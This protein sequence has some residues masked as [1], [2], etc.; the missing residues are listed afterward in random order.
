MRSNMGT[1][2][3][4]LV[5]ALLSVLVVSCMPNRKYALPTLNIPES[6]P[7]AESPDELVLSDVAWYELYAGAEL[8]SLI[9]KALE[10]NKDMV[11]AAAKVREVAYLRRISGAAFLPEIGASL[12]A[13]RDWK[14]Y[15]GDNASVTDRFDAKLTFSWEIDLTGRL[16]WARKQAV[17]EYLQS[18][19]A[20]RALQ[21]S[22][23][24]QVAG[25]YFELTALCNELEIVRQTLTMREEAVRQARLR[26]EGGLTDE[27]PYR[28]AQVELAD[29]SA[30]IPGMERLMSGKRNEIMMLCGDF[31]GGGHIGENVAAFSLPEHFMANISSDLLKR[32]PDVMAAQQALIAAHAAMGIA[33]ADR[34]PKLMLTGDYGLQND[35]ISALLQ[36]PHGFIA[37][38][39]AGPLFS[40]GA[41]K[42]RFRARQAAWQQETARYEQAV[43]TVFHEASNA[44]TAYDAAQKACELKRRLEQASLKS[45]ELARLQYLNG[46]IG[47]LDLLDAQRSYFD[48]R[49][50]L[51][52]AA[53]D[54]NIAIVDLYKALGGGW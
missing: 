18:V 24:A 34:F 31:P 16:R 48:A 23:I 2:G 38:T 17:A 54:E 5:A 53:R 11:V 9:R 39:L 3:R 26:F 6:I 10:N 32:R 20:R 30:L 7:V 4:L 27:T 1:A 13:D 42:A 8:Q 43:L 41:N 49:I 47:Y 28:Q 51:N 19:E 15:G 52:N 36:S 37:G 33:Y 44:I 25:A 45:L 46:A 22:L 14:N 21:M 35:A 12:D 50:G 40:F 29:A